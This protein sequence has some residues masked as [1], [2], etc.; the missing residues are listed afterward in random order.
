MQWP[1]VVDF[2]KFEVSAATFGGPIALLLKP[3]TANNKPII[4]IL[5]SS[6]KELGLIRWN[7][8]SL[9]KVGWS[10]KEE[11]LC[12]QDDG[13]VLIYDIF[14]NFVRNFTMGKDASNV[15]V[16]DAQIFITASSS[17]GVV[18]LTASFRFYMVTNIYDARVRQLPD[19]PGCDL[20]PSSWCILNRALTPQILIARNSDL[21]LLDMTG[22]CEKQQIDSSLHPAAIL[23]MCLSW[24]NKYLAMFLSS[25]TLWIGSSDLKNTYCKYATDNYSRPKQLAWCGTGAVLM[26]RPMFLLL[27]GPNMDDVRYDYDS[28]VHLIQERDGVRVLSVYSH[29]FIQKVPKELEDVFKIGSVEP[30]AV[31]FES[32]KFFIEGKKEAHEYLKLIGNDLL[33]AVQGCLVASGYEFDVKNQKAL[34]KA[35]SFGKCFLKDYDSKPFIQMCR[36]LRVL[37]ELKSK[38]V[39]I[40]LT[41]LQLNQLTMENVIKRLLLR[42]L[43]W[44]AYEM[45][46]YIKLNDKNGTHLVLSVWACDKVGGIDV[47]GFVSQQHQQQQPISY[48]DIIDKAIAHNRIDLALKLISREVR[49]CEQVP[50]LLKL[51]READALN[52]AIKSGDTDLIFLVVFQWKDKLAHGEFLRS[53][54][55]FPVA[56]QLYLQHCREQNVEMLLDIHYQEDNHADEAVCRIMLSYDDDKFERRLGSLIA[57]Q[58]A[59][60]KAKNDF[61]AK[62]IE[63]QIKLLKLQRR[64]EEEM[65]LPFID[66]SI[67]DTIGQLIGKE[68]HKRVE[69]MRKDFKLSDKR[70][71]W[72]KIQKLAELG[73]WLELDKFSKSKKS[74]IGYEPFVD[75]CI[76]Y[77]NVNEGKNYLSKVLPE[78]LVM[79]HIK[80]G[81][82]EQAGDLAIQTK[83]EDDVD[84]VLSKCSAT[85]NRELYNKLMTFQ[86]QLK[87]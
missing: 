20:P 68:E 34:L 59:S 21:Y 43:Y 58:E 74:P 18:V 61:L 75:V 81:L 32:A 36:M 11:L 15:K 51:N 72:L 41:L 23:E 37:N 79:Y 35:S 2:S 46:R 65:N 87:R 3:S 13:N 53:I 85:S 12:I 1:D 76:K 7:S 27:V 86:S 9:L 82:L 17:I 52:A 40:P 84:L 4:F 5:S 10:L 31:L 57:A 8:G 50:L 55:L 24:D 28:P 63:D 78:H 47:T 73:Q 6:G 14:G 16:T 66:L 69:Q 67:D 60:V 26:N 44:V 77:N 54:R 39:G 25:G 48:R 71:W 64:L 49:V 19:F 56:F 83:N 30:S 38:D 70:F 80:L 29:E 62:L 22:S 42:K 33:H 45:S